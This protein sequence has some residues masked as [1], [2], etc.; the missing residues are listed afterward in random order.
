[1]SPTEQQLERLGRSIERV[2]EDFERVRLAIL[3][4]A[5]PGRIERLL[6]TAQQKYEELSTG[7]LGNPSPPKPGEGPYYAVYTFEG[8]P[9]WGFEYEVHG[10]FE[11]QADILR[12]HPDAD[13]WSAW[14][15]HSMGLDPARSIPPQ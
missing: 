7:N 8:E 5:A 11:T 14:Q 3:D 10:P 12:A 4:P 13:D 6:N 15:L 1:M 2:R 9:E